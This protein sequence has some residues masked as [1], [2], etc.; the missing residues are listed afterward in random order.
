MLDSKKKVLPTP[1]ARGTAP[2]PTAV[3][4]VN[5]TSFQLFTRTSGASA[6]PGSPGAPESPPPESVD[7]QLGP[8]VPLEGGVRTQMEKGLASPLSRV[9]VHTNSIANQLA[10]SLSAKAFTVGPHIAFGTGQYQTNS[11]AGVGL[12]AHELAHVVQQSRGTASSVPLRAALDPCT[13]ALSA[14]TAA[15]ELD[16]SRA[17][18]G[19]LLSATSYGRLLPR[20]TG[21]RAPIMG[22]P[23]LRTSPSIQ[24]TPR[25]TLDPTYA[26]TP[27]AGAAPESDLSHEI[28]FDGDGDQVPELIARIRAAKRDPKTTQTLRIRIEIE[29]ARK[30]LGSKAASDKFEFDVPPGFQ[31]NLDPTRIKV[32]DGFTPTIFEFDSIAGP[33]SNWAFTLMPPNPTVAGPPVYSGEVWLPGPSGYQTPQFFHDFTLP[34]GQVGVHNVLRPGDPLQA[35]PNMWSLDM[36]VGAYADKFRLTFQKPTPGADTLEIS[37]LA[38]EDE[39]PVSSAPPLVAQLKS[40]LN[41]RIVKS[42]GAAL[43]LSLDGSGTTDL[44]VYD[45]LIAEADTSASMATKKVAEFRSHEIT[46][47]ASLGGLTQNATARF[48][49]KQGLFEHIRIGAA[50]DLPAVS[51]ARAIDQLTT[52]A[53]AGSF[54]QQ[55]QALEQMRIE[56]RTTAATDNLITSDTASAW[57]ALAKDISA[58]RSGGVNE[59]T[60]RSAAARQ[61]SAAANARQLYDALLLEPGLSKAYI[62]LPST[63]R[64]ASASTVNP[65][66]GEGR[67]SGIVSI[68]VVKPTLLSLADQIAK[69]QWPQAYVTYN[70]AAEEFDAWITLKLRE[71]KR[72][73]EAGK[74]EG[75]VKLTESLGTLSTKTGVT[76][77]YAVFHSL[78]QFEQSQALEDV[79]LRLYYY[80][81]GGYWRLRDVSRP[82]NIFEDKFKDSGEDVPPHELFLELNSAKHF[83]K[84]FVQYRFTF[85]DKAGVEKGRTA[86]VECTADWD[87]A[88]VLGWIALGLAAAG[89]VALTFGAGSIVV[90]SIFVLSGVAGA[91]SGVADLADAYKHGN[92]QTERVALDVAQIIGSLAGAGAG[93]AAEVRGAQALVNAGKATAAMKVLAE[94]ETAGRLFVPL[95]ATATAADV[96]QFV[97]FA[98]D[99]PAGL[100]AIDGSGGTESDRMRAKVVL[101]AQLGAMGG[102]TLVSVKGTFTEFKGKPPKIKIDVVDE[103]PW[104]SLAHDVKPGEYENALNSA[105]SAEAKAAHGTVPVETASKAK[106]IEVG[107]KESGNALV[108]IEGGKPKVYVLDGAHP[109]V[110][111]EE[112]PHLE[113]LADRKLGKLASTLDEATLGKWP[114]L[115]VK[116]KLRLTRNQ[117]TLE[118][119]AQQRTIK[120]MQQKIDRDLASGALTPGS[121]EANALFKQADDLYQNLEHLVA[122]DTNLVGME[123]EFGK[124][125]KIGDPKALEDVPRLF[126]KTTTTGFDLD[127]NWRTLSRSDFIEAYKAKY[128]NTSLSK[129]QLGERWDLGKRLNPASWHM[130]GAQGRKATPPPDIHAQYKRPAFQEYQPGTKEVPLAGK[131]KSEWDALIKKRDKWKAERAKQE[132][133]AAPDAEALRTARWE[134]NE[135]SRQIGEAAGRQYVKGRWGADPNVADLKLIYP[136]AGGSRTGDFDLVYSFTNNTTK[137]TEYIIVEA[138]GGSSELGSRMSATPAGPK[139]AEQGTRPYYESV[140]DNMAS[141]TLGAEAEAVGKSLQKAKAEDVNYVHVKV[142]FETGD[143]TVVRAVKTNDFKM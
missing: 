112:L 102:L 6:A 118:I 139:R 24:R 35:G 73:D 56:L 132:G 52:Q 137:R 63:G 20:L 113:Q 111:N 94:W 16:A 110:L 14:E 130:A 88:D 138:K 25:T 107:G 21:A 15:L 7:A 136:T 117:L 135:A 10:W 77:V 97:S 39:S 61:S 12:L 54:E 65:Y 142:P 2:E 122:K 121:P 30:P 59:V 53:K 106:M 22:G 98:K 8:G 72:L 82:D 124:T 80:R 100:A 84:G 89:F 114:T 103:V 62:T 125:T 51:A 1:A 69:S 76:P 141:G 93:I 49:V 86:R 31:G 70:K 43:E 58:Q 28:L 36:D 40:P 105:L 116:D 57:A 119:D 55:I 68:Q 143:A 131:E 5:P 3:A 46:L 133:A 47:A 66:T 123:R 109:S 140:R 99:V 128:P 67:E 34:A 71:K 23:A 19:A 48:R 18:A 42:A 27:K 9:R 33:G 129:T 45:R 91:A 37:V 95:T 13:S 60:P 29:Q 38:M 75:A 96:V 17:A 126:S 64:T 127:A 41:V 50:S 11:L 81:E 85:L 90:T 108:R 92:L 104:I 101:L 4:P 74:L 78:A 44:H 87:V 79:P 120:A 32:T 83:P 134:L 26:D 115:S